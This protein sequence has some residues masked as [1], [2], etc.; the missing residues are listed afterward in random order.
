MSLGFVPALTNSQDFDDV[1]FIAIDFENLQ[2]G[3]Q[4]KSKCPIKAAEI[5]DNFQ[6]S[7]GLERLGNL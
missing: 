3:F 1:V 5:E 7:V 4:S 2:K 6:L